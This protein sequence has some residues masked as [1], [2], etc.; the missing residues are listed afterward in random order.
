VQCE[1]IGRSCCQLPSTARTGVFLRTE[2]AGRGRYGHAERSGHHLRDEADSRSILGMYDDREL[3]KLVFG[4][5]RLLGQAP[6]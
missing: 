3:Q 1:E 6:T 5:R 4:T 2:A